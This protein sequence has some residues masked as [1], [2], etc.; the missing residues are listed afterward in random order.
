MAYLTLNDQNAGFSP[1]DDFLVAMPGMQFD[2]GDASR[3]ALRVSNYF[4]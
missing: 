4:V 3:G 1:R 2:A